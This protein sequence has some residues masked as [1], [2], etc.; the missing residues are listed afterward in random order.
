MPDEND[1]E[2][3]VRWQGIT[4]SQ[5][6]QAINLILGFA[7]ATLG[8]GVTLLLNKEFVPVS[9][10]K[11]VF[12]VALISLLVSVGLGIWCIV[13]RLRD[14]RST[15]QV[16]RKR[17]KNGEDSEIQFLRELSDR[18][19]KKT[20]LIFWWQIGTFGIGVLLVVVGVTGT[21]SNKIF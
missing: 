7:V 6:G 12:L 10:Q 18:L 1:R 16:A 20:W 2:A 3:F 9:W 21:I 11:C 17:Q 5:L 13:N 14:A 4:I 8:F 15:A 19:G